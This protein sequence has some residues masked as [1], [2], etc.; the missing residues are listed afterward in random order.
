LVT[1]DPEIKKTSKITEKKINFDGNVINPITMA[2]SAPDFDKD[3]F[4]R[5]Y[6]EISPQIPIAD[7]RF[8]F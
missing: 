4:L 1:S 5:E 2:A 6:T 3:L 8:M 7:N